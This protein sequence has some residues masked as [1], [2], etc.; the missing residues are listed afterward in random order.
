MAALLS[1]RISASRLLSKRLI[2]WRAVGRAMKLRFRRQLAPE[3]IRISC[4]LCVTHV[5]RPF[6][7]E[8]NFSKHRAIKPEIALGPPEHWMQNILFGSPRPGLAAPKRT[9]LVA[10]SLNK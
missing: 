7:G 3:P 8:A 10:A 2:L 4:C 6:L 1:V 9:V 5:H